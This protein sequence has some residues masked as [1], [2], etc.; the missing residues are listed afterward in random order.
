MH[1]TI[2][3][4]RR[5]CLASLLVAFAA[6]LPLQGAAAATAPEIDAK[7]NAAIDRLHKE[8]K[9]SDAVTSKSAG[10]LVFPG[11]IKAGFVIAGEGGEG[12]LRIGGKTAGYYNIGTAS[13]GFQGGAQKRDIIIVFMDEASL[14]KFQAS[15]GWK[16]GADASVAVLDVGAG[17]NID[18]S[19]I[20]EPVVGFVVGQSGL[21][22]GVSIDGSKITQAKK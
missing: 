22:A 19:K 6:A 9:G 2:S 13:V 10:Y 18:V 7:V 12:A 1:S 21:M 15:D 11:V 16:A 3:S 4:L 17:A 8:V 14:K 5:A 20:K